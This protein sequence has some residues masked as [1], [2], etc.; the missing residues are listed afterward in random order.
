VHLRVPIP[1]NVPTRRVSTTR[2]RFRQ[3]LNR[4][5]RGLL[6]SLSFSQFWMLT[7]FMAAQS[8]HSLRT[9]R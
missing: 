5:S 1:M 4:P 7:S 9:L 6:G 2:Q 3:S 8:L